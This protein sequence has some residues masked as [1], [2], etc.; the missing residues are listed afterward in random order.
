MNASVKKTV[1]ITYGTFDLFHYGH[2]ALLERAK[3][4]GDYLI[5]GITSDNFDRMRGKLNVKQTLAERIR[6]VEESGIADEIVVEEFKGQKIDD[7]RKHHVDIFAIGS[8]WEGRFDYL[9]DYCKVV[10]LPRTKGISSTA[11]RRDATQAIRLG[12]I[13]EGYQTERI[14]DEASYVSGLD[15][16]AVCACEGAHVVA[17]KK[18]NRF[19][20]P[21]N[22]G[23]MIEL[24]DAV[25]INASPEDRYALIKQALEAGLHV[26]Y[27]GSCALR[28]A[29]A[30]ELISLADKK[31]L[32]L[33]EALQS[34]WL[35]GFQRLELLL[36]SGV[37]GQIKDIDAA[38]S[39]VPDSLDMADVYEGSF[40][41]MA[42]RTLLPAL[43]FLGTSP[44]QTQIIRN[45]EDGFCTWTK[46]NLLYEGASATV[47]AGRGIKTEGDM[48]I[49]GTNGYVY[50]PSPWWK[51]EY[52]ELRYEDL[53][54][55]KKH[56]YELAGEGLRYMLKAFLEFCSDEAS[57]M[58]SSNRIHCEAIVSAALLQSFDE[59]ECID[60]ISNAAKYGG[61]ETV[62]VKPDEVDRGI[63]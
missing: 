61:G 13:G 14:I 54:E 16:T 51:L 55:T 21:T 40:Y 9:N 47:K 39:Q 63:V 57:Y 50:V 29:E 6:G 46:C 56:F 35:P 10:Y 17:A 32:V 60:L 36:E 2:Q 43:A 24:A 4:L 44:A 31:Q 3:A 26:L 19:A 37:V 7:I 49:T 23:E 38:F 48:T 12:C 22:L 28:R 45:I 58:V 20:A 52:F 34:R 8:D 42:T 18:Q 62:I 11:L 59:G 25:Y 15:I 33:M 5:V 53:R 27:E 30:E 1:V 41:T